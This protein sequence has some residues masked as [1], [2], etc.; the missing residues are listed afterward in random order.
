MVWIWE[1]PKQPYVAIPSS[2]GGM[3]DGALGRS[4][5]GDPLKGLEKSSVHCLL[6]GKTEEK[7]NIHYEK[8]GPHQAL[9]MPMP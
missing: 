6:P 4:W 7:T 9:N 3:K 2:K 5:K 1:S 8:I